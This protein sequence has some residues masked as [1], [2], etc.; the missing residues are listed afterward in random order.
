MGVD[1]PVE[2]IGYISQEINNPCIELYVFFE[3]I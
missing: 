2:K 3:N 1:I